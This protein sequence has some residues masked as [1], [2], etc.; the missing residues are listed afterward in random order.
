[1]ENL[2][3]G[4]FE[5]GAAGEVFVRELSENDP[6]QDGYFTCYEEFT[7]EQKAK[8]YI[9]EREEETTVFAV[10]YNYPAGEGYIRQEDDYSGNW[11]GSKH[12]YYNYVEDFKTREKAENCLNEINERVWNK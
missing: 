3:Y 1:M 10:F 9:T 4:V 12:S 5:N 11:K 7:S 8:N 2:T 6:R